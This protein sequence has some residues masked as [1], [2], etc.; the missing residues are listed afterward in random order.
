MSHFAALIVGSPDTHDEQMAPYAEQDVQEKYLVFED[1][2]EELRKDWE[3]E[4]IMEFY[5]SSSSSWRQSC[6]EF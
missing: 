4:P 2:E 5:D 6:G 3:T 1:N